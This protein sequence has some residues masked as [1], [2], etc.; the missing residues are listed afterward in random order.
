MVRLSSATAISLCVC[1]SGART[2]E[3]GGPHAGRG[4]RHTVHEH[5]QLLR[6]VRTTPSAV[7]RMTS[8]RPCSFW[9]PDLP[10]FPHSRLPF[11]SPSDS[12]FRVPT[13]PVI[14]SPHHLLVTLCWQVDGG[15]RA[16]ARQQ[17]HIGWQV[18]WRQRVDRLLPHRRRARRQVLQVWEHHATP[19]Y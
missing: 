11:H 2:G 10:H 13:R 19:S 8:A 16:P 7:H 5:D 3:H 1:V 9:S 17:P 18:Q 14:P 6:M 4:E 15:R 12:D